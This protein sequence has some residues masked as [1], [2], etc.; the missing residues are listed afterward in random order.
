MLSID[1]ALPG[2]PAAHP[3]RRTLVQLGGSISHL[4]GRPLDIVDRDG[5]GLRATQH[6]AYRRQFGADALET[7]RQ[8]DQRCHHCQRGTQTQPGHTG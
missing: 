8:H 2:P 3:K 4:L 6:P 1:R 5:S 7:D